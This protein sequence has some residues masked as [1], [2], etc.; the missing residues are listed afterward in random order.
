LR[1]LEQCGREIAR[2]P[3]LSSLG[4]DELLAEMQLLDAPVCAP[5][6]KGQ[7][8]TALGFL[9]YVVGERTF[10]RYPEAHRRLTAG[11]PGNPTTL[12]SVGID[13]LAEAAREL[14][15]VF[16]EGLPGQEL[17]ARLESEPAGRAWLLELRTFLDRFGHRCPGEFDLGTPRWKEDPSMI[18]GLVR[19]RLEQGG[20]SVRERLSRLWE[21]RRRAMDRAVQAAPLWQRGLLRPLA[22]LVALY[23]PLREAP[24]HYAMVAIERMRL[25]ALELGRRLAER[26]LITAREDVFFLEWSEVRAL[27]RGERLE[28]EA[29]ALVLRRRARWARHCSERAPDFVRS[30]GVPVEEMGPAREPEGVHSGTSVSSGC[31]E[32]S[33]RVLTEPDPL[34]LAPGEVLV[35]AF[36]DPGWT[37]LFPR[38]SAIVMEVGGAMCH[39]AV[40]AR[41]LGIP[42]VFGVQ[43]AASLLRT[44][45]RVRV[46]GDRGIVTL[47]ED[48][49]A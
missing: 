25:A 34:A 17:L 3:A 2:R 35:A 6:R 47:A 29:P 5:F 12:I 45:Q 19:S 13:A 28:E 32:G 15:G 33:V 43:K 11:V 23:M 42:A 9:L 24:K 39:A 16:R 46:D 21:E 48:G 4:T 44:G 41:E 31:A 20:E 8:A 22:R 36:A 40:V 14:A 18:L 38:A 37:P 10:R 27:A 26:G 30:D 1:A 7:Q 49:G